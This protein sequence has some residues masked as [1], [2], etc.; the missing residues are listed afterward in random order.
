MSYKP[1]P[2]RD[3][4]TCES[5]GGNEIIGICADCDCLT[6]EEQNEL[7]NMF[8][9]YPCNE[10]KNAP[11]NSVACFGCTKEHGFPGWEPKE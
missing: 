6:L 1:C 4:D 10:C 5:S 9:A 2:A 11:A 7:F 8:T 3:G